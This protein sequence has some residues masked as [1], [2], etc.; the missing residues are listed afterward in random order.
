MSPA[1]PDVTDVVGRCRSCAARVVWAVT[2]GDGRPIP[3]NFDADPDG[4]VVLL[5]PVRTPRGAQ[6]VARILG[7]AQNT[8]F[9]ESGRPGDTGGPYYRPHWAT[10][11]DADSWRAR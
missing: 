8:L 10:C 6:P 5:D 11:P 9:G 2:E 4:T 7:A 1:G 3:L